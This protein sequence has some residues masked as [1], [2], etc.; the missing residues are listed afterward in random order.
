[1]VSKY[2]F[3]SC[4]FSLNFMV[5][6]YEFKSSI[7]SSYSF[8]KRLIFVFPNEESN[9]MS[10]I[11]IFEKMNNPQSL[12][13]LF[14]LYIDPLLEVKDLHVEIAGNE[15]LKGIS[16]SIYPGETHILFGPN[17]SGKSTLM[18]TLMGLR[19]VFIFICNLLL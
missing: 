14:L 2:D 5:I 9:D 11:F 13:I 12:S 10:L 1:M 17:G 3:E 15:V 8:W 19:F 18:K 16:F 4:V 6:L 7:Y